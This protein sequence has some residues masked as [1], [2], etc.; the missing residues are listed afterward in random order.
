MR[1]R[2]YSVPARYVRHARRRRI[3][4]DRTWPWAEA[5]AQTW[6]R[7]TRLPAAP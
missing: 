6:Q 3:H 4:I 7:L 5:F 2:L 1:H